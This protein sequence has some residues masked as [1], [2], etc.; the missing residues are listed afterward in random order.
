MPTHLR[1]GKLLSVLSLLFL[2]SLGGARAYGDGQYLAPMPTLPTDVTPRIVG[3]GIDYATTVLGRAWDMSFITDFYNEKTDNVR[4]YAGSTETQRAAIQ[5][6][7][8]VGTSTIGDPYIFLVWPGYP[9][10]QDSDGRYG[11]VKPIDADRF[12]YLVFRMYLSAANGSVGQ[13]FWAK[14]KLL[15]QS[16]MSNPFTVYPGWHTYV[17]DLKMIGKIPTFNTAWGGQIQAL[18]LDPTNQASVDFKID[19]VRLVSDQ[20][21]PSASITWTE[22]SGTVSL[23]AIT[24]TARTDDMSTMIAG[25]LLASQGSY[26]WQAGLLRPGYYYVYKVVQSGSQHVGTVDPSPVLVQQAPMAMIDAPG[27]LSGNDYATIVLNDPWDMSSS[28]DIVATNDVGSLTFSGG[29]ARYTTACYTTPFCNGDPQLTLRTGAIYND[30]RTPIDPKRYHHATFRFKENTRQDTSQGSV[31]RFLFGDAPR[32]FT[33]TTK[34]SVTNEDWN[35]YYLDLKT[36]LL[37]PGSAAWTSYSQINAF[38]FDPDELQ[39]SVSGEVDDIRLTSDPWADQSYTIRWTSGGGSPT[40]IVRLYSAPD[41]NPNSGKTLL[42]QTTLSAGSFAWNTAIVAAGIYYVY[43]TMDD[44]VN[45]L[46]AVYSEL[47]VVI[48]RQAAITFTTASRVATTPD[49]FAEKA[50][51]AWDFSDSDLDLRG[52]PIPDGGSYG[53]SGVTIQNGLLSAQTTNTDPQFFLNMPGGATIDTS[54][55]KK[56]TFRYFSGRTNAIESVQFFWYTV[57]RTASTDPISVYPGWGTYTIDLSGNANWVGN[58][59]YFRMDPAA[60][61]GLQFSVDWVRLTG[62]ETPLSLTWTAQNFNADTRISLYV[63]PA[64]DSNDRTLIAQNITGSGFN[65]NSGGFARGQYKVIALVDDRVSDVGEVIDSQE[66]MLIA[67]GP[68]VLSAPGS[69]TALAGKNLPQN[70]FDIPISNIGGGVLTWTVTYSDTSLLLVE[71]PNGSTSFSAEIPVSVDVTGQTA[72]AYLR[73][74]TVDSGAAGRQTVN[75]TILIVDNL[76]QLFLP[77]VMRP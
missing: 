42:G 56:I 77:I 29:T 22:R 4:P 62:P 72:G 69:V 45:A 55:Y 51:N 63:A 34:D 38:R 59:L 15:A 19:W 64:S 43:M 46:R 10:T 41:Q 5:D 70:R 71:T 7:M 12:R 39:L 6:G 13:V 57:D 14:D 66:V 37:V 16:G 30:T 9:D 61:A 17:V 44:G 50:G 54:K 73:Q 32:A 27:R 24:D 25:G 8:L 33:S 75:A 48:K 20:T 28:T 52:A 68:P 11:A 49:D 53:L 40:A 31:N 76:R 23:Y 35:T 74:I 3:E 65:W 36:A 2:G 18:R 58:V 1:I 26:F 47:P 60:E 21:L 67:A